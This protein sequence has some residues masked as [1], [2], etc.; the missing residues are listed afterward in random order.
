MAEFLGLDDGSLV[1][2]LK[3]G[4]ITLIGIGIFVLSVRETIGKNNSANSG[5]NSGKNRKN[6]LIFPKLGGKCEMHC[7]LNKWKQDD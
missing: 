7:T 4:F 2:F 1:E 6:P 5:A 3:P